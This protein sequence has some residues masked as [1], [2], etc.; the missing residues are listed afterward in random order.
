MTGT[1]P[2]SIYK[3]EYFDNNLLKHE[4]TVSLMFTV[5][6]QAGLIVKLLMKLSGQMT[7]NDKGITD[8]YA[9]G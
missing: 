2:E 1:R 5:S 7:P 6:L 8:K 4:N 3:A 9:Y